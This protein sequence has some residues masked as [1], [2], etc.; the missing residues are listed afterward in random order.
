MNAAPLNDKLQAH[1]ALP[2]LLILLGLFAFYGG[3]LSSGL[4]YDDVLLVKDYSPAELARAFS[5]PWSERFYR[6]LVNVVFAAEHAALGSMHWAYHLNNLLLLSAI[7]F[8]F[9]RILLAL[10]Q[11]PLIALSSAVV[12]MFLPGNAVLASWISTRTDTLCILFF[13]LTVLLFLRRLHGLHHWSYASSLLC[14]AA[15]YLTK[16]SAVTLPLVLLAIQF[17]FDGRIEWKRYLLLAPHFL[18]LAAYLLVRWWVLGSHTLG[19]RGF[20]QAEAVARHSWAGLA[21][22]CTRYIE[23]LVSVFF[24]LFLMP[25]VLT[26]LLVLSALALFFYRRPAGLLRYRFLILMAAWLAITAL[27][28]VFDASPRLLGLPTLGG[29]AFMLGWVESGLT[30]AHGGRNRLVLA[31][32]VYLFAMAEING[33]VQNCFTPTVYASTLQYDLKD[34][35]RWPFSDLKNLRHQIRERVLLLLQDQ[36]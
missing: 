27:P 5:S 15:A 26:A 12:W 25:S 19:A 1:P 24:P 31:S 2:W 4:T 22:L 3:T 10:G 20:S 11:R 7:L 35:R 29:A 34:R 33:M 8:I 9:Y 6:P 16:E 28:N 23:A 36:P 17:F 21:G 14:A 32:L 13:L 18:L 30:T